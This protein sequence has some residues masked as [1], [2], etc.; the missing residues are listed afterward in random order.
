MLGAWH[1]PIR[2]KLFEY[3]SSRKCEVCLLDSLFNRLILKSRSRYLCFQ[4]RNFLKLETRIDY[5]TLQLAILDVYRYIQYFFL[6]LLFIISMKTDSSSLD[7]YIYI[8]ISLNHFSFC[9]LDLRRCI[10]KDPPFSGSAGVS[11]TL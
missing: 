4:G 8:Y 3:I 5:E 9:S 11:S 1:R 6:F 10:G 2:V 7:L